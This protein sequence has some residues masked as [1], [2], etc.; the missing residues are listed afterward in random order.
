[1]LLGVDY[2]KYMFYLCII[3]FNIKN[4]NMVSNDDMKE[5]V[6]PVLQQVYESAIADAEKKRVR[7]YQ[8]SPIGQMNI[9]KLQQYMVKNNIP[10]SA[11]L[12]IIDSDI[13]IKWEIYIPMTEK[14]K[15]NF[16]EKYVNYREFS[17]VDD[18]LY[19]KGYKRKAIS[20]LRLSDFNET[21]VYHMFI[22]KE[23]DRLQKYYSLFYK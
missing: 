9:D 12:I 5:I 6:L 17:K 14:E 20:R 19:E 4:I 23:Y 2:V 16:I 7:K 15:N 13:Y 22:K 3:L 21:T 1:M 11:Q 18:I 10:A 8:Y